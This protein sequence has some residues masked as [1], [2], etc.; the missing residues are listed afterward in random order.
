VMTVHCL[1]DNGNR[2]ARCGGRLSKRKLNANYYKPADGNIW[3]VP[4]FSA[5]S[6]QC[7]GGDSV[8]S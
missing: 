7:I 6:H 8:I 1:C 3:H 5:L 2:C 4:G